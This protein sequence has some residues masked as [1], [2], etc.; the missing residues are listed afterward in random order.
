MLQ[1]VVGALPRPALVIGRSKR[2]LT[3]NEAARGL[4]GHDAA[5]AHYT[6]VLRQPQITDAIDATLADA[7]P[8]QARLM[9]R[10]GGRD[11]NWLLYVNPLALQSSP[12]ILVAFEDV[13]RAEGLGQMRRDFV[14][15]VSHE[16]RTP[17]TALMGF[18]ETLMG[19]ARS[20][21]V[22][23]E[24]FLGMMAIEAERMNR[25]VQDLL[26][27]SRVESEERVRPDQ[28]VDFTQIVRETAEMLSRVM[29]ASSARLDLDLP[30]HPVWVNG[31][32]DQLTQVLRNLVENAIKYG[33]GE[34]TVTMSLPER[35]PALRGPAVVLDVKDNGE[36]I[37]A[38]HLPRLTERFYR[39]DTHRSREK[40]G[41]GL[42]LAIVKHVVGRH[43]GRLRL[44]S[45]PGEGS[46]FTVVL[47]LQ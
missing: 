37:E 12:G 9:L 19:P 42:G 10:D 16:L 23:A 21:T 22:A 45:V 33:A 35:E 41:T 24:K 8:R 43:R 28:R 3:M 5:G 6:T 14:A 7:V 36:G 20:D 31:D 18:I 13:S 11:G 4:L 25:L 38:H 47:P 2:V 29:G 17:L 40:G 27:L 34:V 30:D 1:A 39:V 26:S 46:V 44:S 32:R 15:N